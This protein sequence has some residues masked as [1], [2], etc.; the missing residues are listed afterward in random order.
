VL[1][2]GDLEIAPGIVA[3]AGGSHTPGS[4]HV[5]VATREGP[6]VIAGDATYLYWNNQRHVPVGTSVDPWANLEAIRA[7]QR[8][9]A[10]PFLVLPG[11]DRRV[12]DWF[13]E[14]G[15]GIVHITMEAH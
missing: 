11:H 9:A 4:Q 13:P 10:S 6:V 8:E 15:D 12:M 1:I 3:R 7:M 5:T 2:E 14:V